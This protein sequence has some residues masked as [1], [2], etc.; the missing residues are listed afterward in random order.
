MA[1]V[2]GWVILDSQNRLVAH[3]RTTGKSEP[4][5]RRIRKAIRTIADSS[6]ALQPP[7]LLVAK[8]DGIG[9]LVS[10]VTYRKLKAP[11]SKLE[12]RSGEAGTEKL[13]DA[14]LPLEQDDNLA[15]V[16]ASKEHKGTVT[17]L[18]DLMLENALLELAGGEKIDELAG[19]LAMA[20]MMHEKATKRF[21][22]ELFVWSAE[23]V[24]FFAKQ[25]A[26]ATSAFATLAEQ[27]ERFLV[28]NIG[29]GAFERL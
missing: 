9:H 17:V 21:P 26:A 10:P 18:Y 29:K 4:E 23:M 20:C 24:S 14:I 22:A 28:E 11:L 7:R 15:I 16:F 25:S 13:F 5:K 6:L 2:R 27:N 1:M 3:G 12:V 19:R 8:S